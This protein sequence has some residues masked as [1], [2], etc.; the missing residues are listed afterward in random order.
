MADAVVENRVLQSLW[1]SRNGI[2]D[3][4]ADALAA[5]L[6]NG[7]ARRL[8]A[9]DLWGNGISPRGGKA[10]AAALHTNRALRTLELR[11]NGMSNL[12]TLCAQLCA[13]SLA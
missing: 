13:D 6:S 3:A 4:G 12:P 7:R 10:L 1:L 5:A 9:L 2:G 8:E 11:D